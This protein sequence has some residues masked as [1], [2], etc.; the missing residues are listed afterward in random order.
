MKEK[1]KM[2]RDNFSLVS[3]LR[4]LLRPK[5]LHV[6]WLEPFFFRVVRFVDTN[7]YNYFPQKIYITRK[8]KKK[9]KKLRVCVE[10]NNYGVAWNVIWDI[11]LNA[12]VCGPALMGSIK[13]ISLKRR[14]KMKIEHSHFPTFLIR[15]FLN[16]IHKFGYNSAIER[17][18]P[19]NTL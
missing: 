10:W 15:I 6:L 2:C 11:I 19:N 5:M 16:A 12:V 3:L 13:L 9:E 4:Q 18:P 1:K 8:Y 14:F 17:I 7:L